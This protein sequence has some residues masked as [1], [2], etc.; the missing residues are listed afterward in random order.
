MILAII[1]LDLSL[2]SIIFPF[3]Q[4]PFL[5]KI[6]PIMEFQVQILVII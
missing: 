4:F 2:Q 6:L 1:P 3:I 5:L